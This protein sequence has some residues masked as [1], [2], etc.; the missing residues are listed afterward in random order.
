MDWYYTKNYC[1]LFRQILMWVWEECK[2]PFYLVLQVRNSANYFECVT[3]LL[4][5]LPS[6]KLFKII[7]FGIV[8]SFPFTNRKKQVRRCKKDKLHE[9]G[10]LPEF[11]YYSQLVT[12]TQKLVNSWKKYRF[13]LIWNDK[14]SMFCMLLLWLWL[15]IS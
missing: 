4:C 2:K 7:F 15:R 3:H 8:I 5:I 13:F 14:P 1:N 6:K 12:D 11:K 9:K 10:G